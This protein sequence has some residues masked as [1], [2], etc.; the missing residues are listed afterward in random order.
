MPRKSRIDAPGAL[1]HVIA[2]GIE[3][4]RIFKD[5]TDRNNYWQDIEWVL[6]LYDDRLWVARRRYRALVERGISQGRHADLTAG[7]L[8]RS[9]GGWAAVKAMRKAK[10]FQK[11][12]S[13]HMDG[14]VKSL[15][16]RRA[17]LEE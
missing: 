12:K 10:I 3:R 6:K 15:Y 9:T 16:A 4:C 13:H 17:N 1:H 11:V 14:K 7:G 8:I 5:N 2:Q